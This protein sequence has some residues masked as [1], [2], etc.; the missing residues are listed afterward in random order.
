[1]RITTLLLSS[2][3]DMLEEISS[4]LC[5]VIWPASETLCG[6]IVHAPMTLVVGCSTRHVSLC[7]PRFELPRKPIYLLPMNRNSRALLQN[8]LTAHHADYFLKGFSH[9]KHE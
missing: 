6:V 5:L 7:L 1:M 9:D 2:E 3:M 4:S 8:P